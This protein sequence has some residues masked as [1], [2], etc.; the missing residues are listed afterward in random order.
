MGK[1]YLAYNGPK[2]TTAAPVSVTTGVAIKTLMQLSPPSTADITVIEWGISFDGTN[3][4]NTPI[5]AELIET[6]VAATV[7]AY[8][9]ADVMPYGRANDVASLLTLGT[10]NSGYTSTSEGATTASRLLDLQLLPNTNPFWH[11]FPLGYQPQCRASKFL[12]VRVTAATAV[13][14][15]CYVIWEE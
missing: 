13:N 15:Y 5:K 11:Q 9:A 8:V 4:T 2:V 14:A 12:R 10:A 1:S 3:P 6:D 7:T